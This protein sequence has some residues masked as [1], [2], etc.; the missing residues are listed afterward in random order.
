MYLHPGRTIK[1]IATADF[2]LTEILVIIIG[3]MIF[4]K[5]SN[6]W[7]IGMMVLFFGTLF[8]YIANLLIA[9]FGELVENST[10]IREMMQKG[11][12]KNQNIPS[13]NILLYPQAP[14]A[15]QQYVPTQ[16]MP[17]QQPYAPI[18]NVPVQQY[19][20]PPAQPVS[21]QQPPASFT[22][23]PAQKRVRSTTSRVWEGAPSPAPAPDPE[24]APPVLTEYKLCSVCG[25]KNPASSY[26]CSECGMGLPSEII[27]AQASLIKTCPKCGTDNPISETICKKCFAKI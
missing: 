1:I 8:A 9:A 6:A 21:A 7:W 15:Q 10:K 25:T 24:P 11:T 3:L 26:N 14:D 4:I 23:P 20:N 16:N 27:K 19:N 17:V 22:V 5:H 13:N 18:Q 12:Y 2:V